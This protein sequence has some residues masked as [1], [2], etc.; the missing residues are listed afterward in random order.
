VSH[1]THRL[2][3]FAKHLPSNAT[4]KLAHLITIVLLIPRCK[5]C[6]FG[7]YGSATFC[8]N[9]AGVQPNDRHGQRHRDWSCAIHNIVN[10]SNIQLLGLRSPFGLTGTVA[11]LVVLSLLAWLVARLIIEPILQMRHYH[12]QGIPGSSFKPLIG[13]LKTI[14]RLRAQ[15]ART[16]CLFPRCNAL[17]NLNYDR[18]G[19]TACGTTGESGLLGLTYF[20][21]SWGRNFV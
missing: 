13:D 5:P 19:L 2:V 6:G 17:L 14:A 11:A 4:L 20:T 12:A 21:P 10:M 8:R 3:A 7:N 15:Q 9:F 1:A 18:M 16:S